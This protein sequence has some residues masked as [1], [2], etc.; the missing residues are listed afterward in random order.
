[1]VVA[2]TETEWLGSVVEAAMQVVG[3]TVGV[4]AKEVQAA[5]RRE[6]TAAE[7]KA[8]VG[9]VQDKLGR[10]Q[11]AGWILAARTGVA[12]V[13]AAGAMQPLKP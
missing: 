3:L 5:A 6:A 1:M 12:A 2:P 4:V 10:V 7:E 8:F 11:G 13:A 9:L